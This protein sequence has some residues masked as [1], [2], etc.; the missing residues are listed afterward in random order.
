[1]ISSAIAKQ[2]AISIKSMV[3]KRYLRLAVTAEVGTNK[4]IFQKLEQSN[5]F[6][7]FSLNEISDIKVVLPPAS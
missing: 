6:L 1:M 2:A 5:F 4:H 3:C 7:K